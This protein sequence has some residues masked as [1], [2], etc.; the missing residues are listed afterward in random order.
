M[1]KIIAVLCY[2]AFV[3]YFTFRGK[4]QEKESFFSHKLMRFMFALV[5]FPFF[6]CLLFLAGTVLK[7]FGSFFL[8]PFN[9]NF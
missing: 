9:F 7:F 1:L 6:G 8:A 5:V 2:I 4:T 3:L